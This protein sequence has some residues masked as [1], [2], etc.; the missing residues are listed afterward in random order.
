MSFNYPQFLWA[1]TALAIPI[2]IH[3][4]SFRRTTRI[5]FS[6]TRFLKQ[7]QQETTQQR[8]LKKYLVLASRLLF[9]FFLV[10][11]FAQ[12]FLPAREQL[13]DQRNLIIYLDNSYS[14]SVPVREKMRALDAGLTYVREIVELFPTE[15]RYKLITN[16]FA[17]FSNTFKSKAEISDLLSQVRLSPVSR[18]FQEVVQRIGNANTTVFW[19]SDFQTSTLGETPVLDSTWQIR[20]VPIA[21][22]LISNVFVDSVWLDNPFIIG[23]EKNSV[24]VRLHNQGPRPLEGLITKLTIGGVQAA[25][26]AL[27]IESNSLAETSFDLS[28]DL[29]GF[30]S[31][32]VSFSDYPVSFDNEFN[33]ALNYTGRLKVVEI[34]PDTRITNVQQVYGNA[35]LFNFNT[36]NIGNVDYSVLADADVV[37]LNG[38][39]SIDNALTAALQGYRINNGTLM[40]IPGLQP[41]V[42]DYR[43]LLSMPQ[44]SLIAKP[45]RHV[46]DRPDF[47]NPFFENVFEERTAAMAMPAAASVWDWGIDRSGIL[48]FAD[49]KPYLSRIGSTFLLGSSLD[50][51]VSDLANHAIFVPIMYRIAASGKKADRKPYYYLSSALITVPAD[52]LAGD[53]PA[54]MKGQQELIPSQRRS[55]NGLIL[56]VPRHSVDP[57]FYFVTHGTDTLDML[58]FNL[59]KS[60]SELQQLNGEAIKTRLGGGANISFFDTATAN[61]F[62]TEIESR[63]LGK[64]LWKYAILLALVFLLAEVLLI[65]FLK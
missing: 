36:F 9:I 8:K 50:T 46:L 65:R 53:E 10:M 45:E 32:V 23:G 48:K 43:Q 14:M 13:T 37:I 59:G 12:P 56:E 51:Q 40:V 7:I 49:G 41:D 11:A 33:F 4:F 61:S 5:Y 1:L 58:A 27:S 54:R 20:L 29:K 21:Y 39:N 15:T 38:L 22:P 34:K 63:Y 19:I 55:S 28:G 18:S 31:A 30:N 35:E 26:T 24:H 3:L 44:L 16:D 47:Q 62:S 57:G 25:T 6:S 17:P 2:I 64:P 52:S 42:A 60:E